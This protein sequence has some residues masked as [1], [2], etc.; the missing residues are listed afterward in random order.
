M[1]Y[2]EGLWIVFGTDA[3][4]FPHGRNAE[5]FEHMVA[6]GIPPLV[7][8]KSATIE[9]ARLLG[10]EDELGSIEVGK[11]ADMIAMRGDPLTDIGLLKSVTFVM[12]TMKTGRVAVVVCG[13]A[14]L[15]DVLNKLEV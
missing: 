2:K 6:A 8:V 10:I 12:K 7:A 14:D 4:V 3:G 13:V 5:E 15:K 11:L 9:A 1:A